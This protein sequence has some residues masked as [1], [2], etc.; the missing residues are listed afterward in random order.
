MTLGYSSFL[1]MTP[2]F[3]NEVSNLI[4]WNL[5]PYDIPLFYVHICLKVL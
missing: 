4:S 1:F 3:S 5:F 2:L